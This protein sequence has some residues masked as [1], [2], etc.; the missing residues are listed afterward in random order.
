MRHMAKTRSL[1]QPKRQVS[2]QKSQ[3]AR[4]Q[5]LSS[6]S[7]ETQSVIHPRMPPLRAVTVMR[8]TQRKSRRKKRSLRSPRK[9]RRTKKTKKLQKE[10]RET[11]TLLLFKEL[12]KIEMQT[13]QRDGFALRGTHGQVNLSQ[14]NFSRSLRSERSF[15]LGWLASKYLISSMSIKL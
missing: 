1:L 6:E 13:G 14:T 12:M 9:T 7:A 2:L 10:L 15:Q 5:K 3:R 11:R 8:N 4:L